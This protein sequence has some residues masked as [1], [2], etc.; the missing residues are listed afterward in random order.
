MERKNRPEYALVTGASSGIGFQYARVLAG[1]GYNIVAVSNEACME[2]K[3]AELRAEFPDC[4]VRP[5]VMDLGRVDAAGEL[6]DLC[7]SEGLTVEVLVNNAGVYHDRDFL[8]DSEAFTSLILLLHCYTPAMLMHRFAPDMEAR[9]RGYILNMSSVTSDFGAQRLSTYSS[10][11]G[12]L[13]LLSRATHVELRSKGVNVT[14]VRPG[15][16]ATTL[17]NL[18]PAA[19]KAGLFFGYI[20]TPERLARKGVR[21]LFRGRAQITPGLYTKLLDLLVRLLPTSA[22]RLIRRLRIF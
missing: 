12:F 9:G 14:C 16:V 2:E 1:Y 18:K 19:M 20:I 13:R 3:A 15:A 22:L 4:K 11:K 8:D 17:Y 21:A 5:V 10:T 7:S 6:Y